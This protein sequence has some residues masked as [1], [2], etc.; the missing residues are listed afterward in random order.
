MHA[1]SKWRREVEHTPALCVL[2][3]VWFDPFVGLRHE[4]RPNRRVLAPDPMAEFPDWLP[5]GW[6]SR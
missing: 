1:A 6:R 3:A 2:A 5:I 4:E